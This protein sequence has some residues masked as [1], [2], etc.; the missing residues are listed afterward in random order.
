MDEAMTQCWLLIAGQL[1][2][3][4]GVAN[5]VILGVE[6]ADVGVLEAGEELCEELA[7][8]EWETLGKVC[9]SPCFGRG[10]RRRRAASIGRR[11]A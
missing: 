9:G 8:A 7:S 5:V 6:I 10:G 11:A 1:C 4:C 2:W 3:R